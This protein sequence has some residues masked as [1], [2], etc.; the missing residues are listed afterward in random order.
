L[1]DWSD[2]KIYTFKVLGQMPLQMTQCVQIAASWSALIV[3]S[4]LV[5]KILE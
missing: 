1:Y 3:L 4:W 5:A 2:Q